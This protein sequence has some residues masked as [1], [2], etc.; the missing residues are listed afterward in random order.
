MRGGSV[1]SKIHWKMEIYTAF[2]LWVF[3]LTW[4]GM[5]K[6]SITSM[7]MYHD[8]TRLKMN[9]E[10]WHTKVHERGEVTKFKIL[11]LYSGQHY[12]TIYQKRSQPNSLQYEYI[13]PNISNM[14]RLQTLT[15]ITE[16]LIGWVLA[17]WNSIMP[18]EVG[19]VHSLLQFECSLTFWHLGTCHWERCSVQTWS[20]AQT[21]S[22]TTTHHLP[23]TERAVTLHKS[24]YWIYPQSC[25]YE[26]VLISP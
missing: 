9:E 26:G 3:H 23:I 22:F 25:I 24:Y 18:S 5:S 11:T 10:T 13:W 2:L 16:P 21:C 1:L 6:I 4:W 14:C 12:Y 15:L 17:V 19:A 7:T 8:H 20:M